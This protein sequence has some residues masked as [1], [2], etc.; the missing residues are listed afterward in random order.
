VH[1]CRRSDVLGDARV[2]QI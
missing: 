2:A 1:S